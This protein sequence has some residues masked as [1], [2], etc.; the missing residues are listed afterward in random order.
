MRGVADTHASLAQL[1]LE[2]DEIAAAQEHLTKCL[3]LGDLFGLPQ[4]PYRCRVTQARV[5]ILRGNL[6]D[7]VE[8]LREAE[9]SYVSD[10]LSQCPSHPGDERQGM[11]AS[12][13]KRTPCL[14]LEQMGISDGCRAG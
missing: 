11:T 9:R 10:F 7:A 2:R 13:A 5:D 8:E 4:H 14:R 3:E 1:H 6:A 12:G